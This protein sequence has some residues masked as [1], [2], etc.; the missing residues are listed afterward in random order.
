MSK[1]NRKVAE[2]EQN[3]KKDKSPIVPQ[4]DKIK[5]PLTIRVRDDLTDKQKGLLDLIK[6]KDTKIVMIDGPAGT[7]KTFISVLAGLQLLE[8]HRV[9]DITYLRSAVE[10]TESEIGFLPGSMEEK[11]NPYLQPLMDKVSEFLPSGQTA[12]LVK[13]G[14]LLG[15][16]TGFLRGL[17]WNAKYIIFDEAQNASRK[18]LITAM[19]RLGK[20]S[21]M[22]IIGDTFQNDLGAK[23]GFKTMFDTFDDQESRNEGIYCL[24]LTKDDIVRSGVLKFI[25]DK[26][27]RANIPHNI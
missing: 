27:E 19:T 5:E 24:R 3:A 16:H 23:S 15:M 8:D 17:S 18:E 4:G 1:K 6:M 10:S 7:A 26:L 12:F 20:F 22:I 21:K 25:I 11:I 13:D 9:S 2:I 14:R